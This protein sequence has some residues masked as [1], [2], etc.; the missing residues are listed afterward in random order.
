VETGS[1]SAD[2]R[3]GRGGMRRWVTLAVAVLMVAGVAAL[4]WRWTHRKE[5]ELLLET[6]ETLGGRARVDEDDPERPLIGADL[7]G[8]DISDAW[9]ARLAGQTRLRWLVLGGTR[10][11]DEGLSHLAGLTRLRQLNLNNSRVTA[12]GLRHLEGMTELWQLS[13]AGAP[14]G[15][16]AVQ[17]LKKLPRLKE[18]NLYG[19]HITRPGLEALQQAFPQA[20]IQ[21]SLGSQPEP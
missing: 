14:V 1:L 8:A 17:T 7:H 19:T 6:I 15:D 16:D 11:G 18:L 2:K 10:I 4:V 20:R 21:T 3:P 9:L 12:R 13:L 5:Q